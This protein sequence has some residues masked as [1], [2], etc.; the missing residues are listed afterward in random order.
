MDHVARFALD[1]LEGAGESGKAIKRNCSTAEESTETN[2]KFDLEM[3][4]GTSIE[5]NVISME[6]AQMLFDYIDD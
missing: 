6:K 3:K 4:D 5:L 1:T 2:E